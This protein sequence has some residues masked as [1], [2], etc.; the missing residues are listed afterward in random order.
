MKKISIVIFLL[1][2]IGTAYAQQD[3]LTP[4]TKKAIKPQVIK[5]LKLA[6]NEDGSHYV[7]FTGLI[8]VWVRYNQSNPNSTVNGQA[9]NAKNTFDIGL[10]RVRFQTMAQ[11]T[12]RSYFYVQIGENSYNYLSARKFGLFL[13]DATG[14]YE[15]IKKHLTIG[16]GLGSWV[17]PLR[18]SA[19]GV[20]SL[21]GMDGVI[22]QQTTNDLNDQFVRR[23]MV[24]AK[25]KIGKLDYRV[26]V[27]KPFIVNSTTNSPSNITGGQAGIGILTKDAANAGINGYMQ[28][29]VATFSTRGPNP[30]LNTYLMYQFFDQETNK[31][32]YNTG[33]YYG[34]KKILNVGG[35]IQYQKDAMWYTQ[36][37]ASH[38]SG[39][40]TVTHQLLTAGIDVFY[41]APLNKEKGTAISFY[42]AYLYSDYG[43]NYVRNLGVMNPADAG[44]GYSGQSAAAGSA[45]PRLYNSGGGS[46]YAMNGTGNTLSAQIG[47][48]LKD[49]LLGEHGTLMPY[50]MTQLSTFQYYDYKIMSTFDIGI[51]WLIKGHHSK[52]S[53]DYQNRPY[54]SQKA[55]E[56]PK[57]TTRRGMVVLQYQVSF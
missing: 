19:P 47:Y 38:A 17:G 1:L 52:F 11:L 35:G 25:G 16:A 37:N 56:S 13:M 42:A 9:N 18:Y 49:D 26:S 10:R 22:Y 40:D 44:Q 2:S 23:F 32:P 41:D 30:Q 36:A 31:V 21:M 15:F 20:G 29:D 54:F 28:N 7:Q 55:G 50:V 57:E 8:Q 3:T 6:L 43:K 27:S 33:T 34:T 4:P 24:Y 14:D 5:P 45:T 12:D 51:N 53:L 39:I 48:K 46:A